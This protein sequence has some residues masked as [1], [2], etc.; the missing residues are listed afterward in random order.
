MVTG[1]HH[2]GLDGLVAGHLRVAGKGLQVGVGA[3]LAQFRDQL[4]PGCHVAL[5]GNTEQRFGVRAGDCGEL[6]H[7]SKLALYAGKQFGVD[8]RVDFAA[9]ELDFAVREASLAVGL[10][11]AEDPLHLAQPCPLPE[12]PGKA[13]TIAF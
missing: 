10:Q 6:G 4:G 12:A 11:R 13:A 5:L 9:Q 1:I 3:Y 8:L 2:G 7:G